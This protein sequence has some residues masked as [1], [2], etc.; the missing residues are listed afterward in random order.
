M[1]LE[2]WWD[3][4]GLKAMIKF[5][6]SHKV[7]IFCLSQPDQLQAYNSKSEGKT[8]ALG[9]IISLLF[10]ILNAGSYQEEEKKR[11]NKTTRWH[12]EILSLALTSIWLLGLFITHLMRDNRFCSMRGWSCSHLKGA[13]VFLIL[14]CRMQ[15]WHPK[16]GTNHLV[17]G[18]T[19]ALSL[20]T[21]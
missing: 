3:A 5:A 2:G 14:Y 12:C 19:K 18:H 20:P 8:R 10:W 4:V 9:C 11:I 13:K 21:S 1:P 7:G 17:K 6:V 16:I 15:M